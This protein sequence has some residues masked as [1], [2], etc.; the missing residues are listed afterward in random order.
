[1]RHIDT[2]PPPERLAMKR[3]LV[4][5]ATAGSVL[6]MGAPVAMAA[7]STPSPSPSLI[8]SNPGTWSPL[9]AKR[10]ESGK[11]ITLVPKQAV[12][13]DGF[14]DQARFTS[15]NPKVFV[16][17]NAE[18]KGTYTAQAGGYAVAKGKATVTVTRAGKHVAHFDIVVK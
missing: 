12:L 1:M 4:A 16:A 3:F 10:S 15:S 11:T 9:H 14:S 17:S 18:G 2:S 7:D 6:L 5:L 13:F 8:G